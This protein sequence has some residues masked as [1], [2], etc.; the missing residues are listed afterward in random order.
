MRS[1]RVIALAATA[2]VVT[3]GVAGCSSHKAADGGRPGA[4]A[5]ALRSGAPSAGGNGPVGYAFEAQGTQ[6]VVY[7]GRK[8]NHIHELW[9]G[10]KA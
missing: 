7:P 1:G 9:W 2:F 8:D 3:V 6:H 4:A 5:P 10:P